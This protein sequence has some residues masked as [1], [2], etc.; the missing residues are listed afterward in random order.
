MRSNETSYYMQ[1]PIYA[2]LLV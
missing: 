2:Y 1:K